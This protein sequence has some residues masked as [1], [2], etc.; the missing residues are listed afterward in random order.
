MDEGLELSIHLMP[1]L[2]YLPIF[3]LFLLFYFLRKRKIR[4][5]KKWQK[6]LNLMHHEP[7]FQE[8]YKDVN[9]FIL[10]RQAREKQDAFEF[11]YGEI[12]FL[13]FIALL[14][15]VK[16]DSTTVFYDLGSGVGKAV[17]ACAMVY[18]VR[19]SLGIELF[20]QLHL[21]ACEQVEKLKTIN[22]YQIA[23]E[24]IELIEGNILEA[25]LKDAT[26][27]FI[28]A[29]ALI[30]QTWEDLC[31]RLNNLPQIE[32]IITTSKPLL[33]TEFWQVEHTKIQMSWGVVLAYIHTT[34]TYLH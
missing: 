31:S 18:P 2:I 34:K 1:Y 27:I 8:I 26:L 13:P 10:S 9:G 5:I 32:A 3:I 25:D 17:L 28:N 30:G 22:E 19:K 33:N 24:K 29:T 16:I 6:S 20:H 11:T 14:S 4:R 7:V 12:E 23:A 21:C 15:L